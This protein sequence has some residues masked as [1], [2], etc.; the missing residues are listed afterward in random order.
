MNLSANIKNGYYLFGDGI[1]FHEPVELHVSRF[2]DNNRP[3]G[4]PRFDNPSAFKVYLNTTEPV[5]SANRESIASV[6]EHGS[7]YNLVL[8]SDT[9]VL[10]ELS[11]AS[12]FPYGTTWLNKNRGKIDHEDGL[13]EYSPELDLLHKNKKFSVSFLGTNHL[14]GPD[15]YRMRHELWSKKDDIKTPTVFYSSTRHP[16]TPQGQ[17]LPEDNKKYLFNSQFSIAIE[18]TSVE[19]YFSEKLIDCLISKTIPIYWGCPN[20]DEFFDTRG[21]IIVDSVDD[22]INKINR[23]TEKS[24]KKKLKYVEENYALAHEYARPF[25]DR[26]RDAIMEKLPPPIEVETKVE[27]SKYALSVGIVSLKKR[28]DLLNRLLSRMKDKTPPE[29]MERVE[30]LI[31]VD[32]GAK[33]VGQKRNEILS[34]ATGKFI[35]FIDDDDLVS[36]N[37]LT[38]MVHAIDSTPKLDCIGFT[39][40]FYNDDQPKMMFKHANMYRG[41]YKDSDGTQYRPANH[42]NPVRTEIAKKI[43]FPEKNFGEDADYSDKLL[44]SGLINDEIIVDGEVMYH[45]LFSRSQSQTH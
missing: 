7:K 42:L 20:I 5:S 27:E 12:F 44:T 33:P 28:E 38:T 16:M 30:V 24:Y 29:I 18:S 32:E 21:M 2:G 26:V 9:E 14:P 34:R 39:G 25:S 3:G 23:L 17:L 41:N 19:N 8:T 36:E 6:I 1:D 40:M 4:S 35:C 10:N 13:G 45:Y 37:Y 22:M 15:G 11:N 31:N 43:G